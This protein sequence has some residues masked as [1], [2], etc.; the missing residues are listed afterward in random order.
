MQTTDSE[1][2]VPR[3]HIFC[4]LDEWNSNNQF[5]VFLELPTEMSGFFNPQCMLSI[6]YTYICLAVLMS[7][8]IYLRLIFAFLYLQHVP[9]TDANKDMN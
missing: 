4:P 1:Q 3:F 8:C 5:S 6:Q 7:G 9:I 2:I